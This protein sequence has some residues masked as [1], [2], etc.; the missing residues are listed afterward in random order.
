METPTTSNEQTEKQQK[1]VD[2]MYLQLKILVNDATNALLNAMKN[3]ANDS[4]FQNVVSFHERALYV[5]AKKYVEA[6]EAR[7]HPKE[8]VVETTSEEET[9]G[10]KTPVTTEASPA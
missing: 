4:V 2:T 8:T 10:P 5:Q 1:I 3:D 6:Y 9:T 7:H